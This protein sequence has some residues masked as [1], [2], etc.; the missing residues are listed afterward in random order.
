MLLCRTALLSITAAL[1]TS[2][3]SANPLGF[4]ML[5]S[6]MFPQAVAAPAKPQVITTPITAQMATPPPSPQMATNPTQPQVASNPTAP[7]MVTPPTTPQVATNPT[8]PQAPLFLPDMR[9]TTNLYNIQHRDV[10]INDPGYTYL[11]Q[12]SNLVKHHLSQVTWLGVNRLTIE[13]TTFAASFANVNWN[14]IPALLKCQFDNQFVTPEIQMFFVLMKGKTAFSDR[15][16]PGRKYIQAPL[17]RFSFPNIGLKVRGGTDCFVYERVAG[18]TLGHFLA[19]KSLEERAIFL[20]DIFYKVASGLM[21]LRK[22]NVFFNPFQSGNILIDQ[23]PNTNHVRVKL[24]NYINVGILTGEGDKNA[25]LHPK[26]SS[27]AQLKTEDSVENCKGQNA[28]LSD[29]LY[30]A[31]TGV[32]PPFRAPAKTKAFDYLTQRAQL[33]SNPKAKNLDPHMMRPMPNDPGAMEF[34]DIRNTQPR[35]PTV[36]DQRALKALLPLYQATS[37]LFKMPTTDCSIND[38]IWR[39]LSPSMRSLPTAISVMRHK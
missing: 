6:P 27:L 26:F 29:I 7:Q 16:V 32:S 2:A 28:I 15:Q 37:L 9:K 8:Q 12:D 19:G 13:K 14:N 1:L 4:Q 5:G 33:V 10:Y 11:D 35:L 25:L 3:V 22:I 36:A 21:Y 17:A 30:Y 24:Y 18:K 34:A 20:P 38:K 31:L 23:V 39:L